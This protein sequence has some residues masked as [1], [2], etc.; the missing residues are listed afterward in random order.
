M[1]AWCTDLQKNG[2]QAGEGLIPHLYA[3]EQ[4]SALK[5]NYQ[6]YRAAL[7]QSQDLQIHRHSQLIATYLQGDP[8]FL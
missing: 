3:D 6:A 1:R 4:C 2:E 8:N 7:L 5:T